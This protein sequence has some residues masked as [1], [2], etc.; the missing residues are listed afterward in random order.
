MQQSTVFSVS[1]IQIV[2]QAGNLL[3]AH[4]LL[5]HNIGGNRSDKIRRAVYFRLQRSDH[6]DHWQQAL[7]DPWYNFDGIRVYL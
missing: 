2:G 7:Q 1:T 4:Y 6:R 3:S 5:A